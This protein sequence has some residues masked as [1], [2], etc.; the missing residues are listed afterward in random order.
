MTEWCYSLFGADFGVRLYPRAIMSALCMPGW[1]CGVRPQA[2]GLCPAR[3][4]G[5]LMGSCEVRKLERPPRYD[6]PTHRLED[7]ARPR[8][9][10]A[11]QKWRHCG[12]RLHHHRQWVSKIS[13]CLSCLHH[14]YV[15][16]IHLSMLFNLRQLCCGFP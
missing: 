1:S 2:S 11:P 3:S 6:W 13:V 12:L 7:G 16:A 8:A 9:A 10:I 15:Q 4:G 14:F 5:S